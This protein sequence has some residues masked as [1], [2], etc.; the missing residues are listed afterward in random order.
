M[1]ETF[2]DENSPRMDEPE[3]DKIAQ[4]RS[5]GQAVTRRANDPEHTKEDSVA[6]D[7][8]AKAY[9]ECLE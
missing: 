3:A 2:E 5:A 6:E 1:K 9:P 4:G 7:K 8:H